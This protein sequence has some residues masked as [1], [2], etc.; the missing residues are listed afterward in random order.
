VPEHG[1]RGDAVD[2]VVAVDDDR[3]PP[4][5]GLDDAF[6][7]PVGVREERGVVQVTE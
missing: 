7:G 6:G 2:V 3:L 1:G 4:L 5:E